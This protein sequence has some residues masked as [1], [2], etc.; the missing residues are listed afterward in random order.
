MVRPRVFS[1]PRRFTP[2]TTLQV[3]FTLITAMGF[4]TFPTDCTAASD[5]CLHLSRNAVYTPRRIPLISSR[6]TSLWPLPS[7]CYFALLYTAGRQG[8]RLPLRIT[9]PERHDSPACCSRAV[10]TW[11]KHARSQKDQ[12]SSP[13]RCPPQ[14]FAVTAHPTIQH[15]PDGHCLTHTRRCKLILQSFRLKK[16]VPTHRSA[17]RR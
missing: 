13:L 6:T 8:D 7:C 3:Y 10:T 14:C 12:R 9:S 17:K 1:T 11:S 15:Y 5:A 4:V 2:V 16:S